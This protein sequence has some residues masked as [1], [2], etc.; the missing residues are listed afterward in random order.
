[1]KFPIILSKR[2]KFFIYLLTVLIPYQIYF[3]FYKDKNLTLFLLIAGL[4]VIFR[5]K[6][7]FKEIFKDKNIIFYIFFCIFLVLSFFRSYDKIDA[8]KQLYF[9]FMAI[10]VYWTYKK[11][12]AD[13][14]RILKLFVIATL[15]LTILI[16]FLFKF[17]VRYER[18]FLNNKIA[19]VFIE[20]DSLNAALKG[21]RG[22]N[23]MGRYKVGGFFL[24]GNV[25]SLY[26]GLNLGIIF[27]FIIRKKLGYL[28]VGI[29]NLIALAN[30][31]SYAG[32]GAFLIAIIFVLFVTCLKKFH[33]RFVLYFLITFILLLVSIKIN[34]IYRKMHLIRD[35]TF[36]GRIRVWRVSWEVIKR[37]WIFGVGLDK[38]NWEKEYNKYTSTFYAPKNESAHN[39]FLFLW[40]KTGIFSL[41]FLILFL[42]M[43]F[44]KNLKRF[45][46]EKNSNF[47]SLVIVFSLILVILVGMT[48]NIF[49]MN[50]RILGVFWM[51]IGL[52]V[53]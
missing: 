11:F 19:K 53:E 28:A 45:F 25:A 27:W 44:F 47:Y 22:Y 48:E 18:E 2:D 50:P 51:I 4:F 37:N 38:E 43:Q 8:F 42:S 26:I 23:A 34:P 9:L 10:P 6:T 3:S 13:K 5:F 52:S 24:N 32:M 46:K 29:L 21:K 40:A 7:F 33:F 41:M 12:I 16:I 36:H 31:G 49:F 20:P 14:E 35:R 17:E 39:M 15:P 1:M 30:T